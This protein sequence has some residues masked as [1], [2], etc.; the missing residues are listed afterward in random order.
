LI[1]QPKRAKANVSKQN[2]ARISPNP[3]LPF[4]GHAPSII[5]RSIEELEWL[6]A[7]WYKQARWVC[8]LG[9]AMPKILVI[10]DDE[11]F[12]GFLVAILEPQGFEVIQAPSG[13]IGFQLARTHLPDL[14]LCDVNMVGVGGTLTLHA[15]RRDPQIASIP[16]ILMSGALSDDIPPERGADGSLAKPFSSEKLLATVRGALLKSDAVSTGVKDSPVDSQAVSSE[17]SSSG[18][19]ETLGR[20]LDITGLLG[21]PALQLQPREI[22]ELAGQAR[23]AASLLH[24]R[25]ENCLLQL[26][27]ERRASDWPQVATQQEHRTGIQGVVEPV[28]RDK[29]RMFQRTADLNLKIDDALAMISADSLKKVMEEL[30]DNAFRYSRPGSAV[31]LK[32][33]VGADHIAFSITDHGCGMTAEQVARAGGPMSLGQVLLAQQG[34]GLGLAISRRLI[35]LH[36]GALTIHSQPGQ[37]TTAT[38]TLAKS[39]GD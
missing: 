25:I 19:L 35:E 26:E 1:R 29:A 10:D 4:S 12:R 14:V 2:Q 21:N 37:G 34:T 31:H 27:I 6:Q 7:R 18:L 24:R 33:S 17:D 38:A 30:L 39:I 5:A 9:F 3:S 28:A 32:T 8:F 11:A 13:P 16:F 23:R 22:V 15:F 20:I 36:C